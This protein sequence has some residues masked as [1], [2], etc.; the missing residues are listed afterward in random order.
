MGLATYVHVATTLPPAATAN[1]VVGS[2]DV[3]TSPAGTGTAKLV[4]VA[5]VPP[6]FVNVAVPVTV[7]P[8]DT[9][10]TGSSPSVRP[11]CAPARPVTARPPLVAV[12]VAAETASCAEALP[13]NVAVPAPSVE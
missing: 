4:T 1:G 5:F 13:V 3:C 7:S 10:P 2:A 9:F 12:T 11:N 6:G 8:N